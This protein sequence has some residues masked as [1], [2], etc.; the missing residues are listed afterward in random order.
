[1]V[2]SLPKISSLVSDQFVI[3]QPC[4]F[5][6]VWLKKEESKIN[7][8]P[9]L[10]SFFKLIRP[11]PVYPEIDSSGEFSLPS[12]KGERDATVDESTKNLLY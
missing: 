6:V 4:Y 10:L 8:L 12:L 3:K 9:P 7:T 2:N 1:M 5:F 11:D